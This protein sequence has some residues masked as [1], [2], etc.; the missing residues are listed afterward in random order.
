[1]HRLQVPSIPREESKVSILEHDVVLSGSKGRERCRAMFDSSASYSIIRR[2]LA[3]RLANLE[4]L[5][6]LEE[7]VFETA[8]PG[9][10]IQA[11]HAVLLV[12]HF[13]DSQERFS[14]EFIV[15]DALPEALIVGAHSIQAWHVTLDFKNESV[16]YPKTARRLRV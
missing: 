4:P 3:E 11:R 8:R 9:D 6:D 1:M 15:F 16:T 5:K 13:D 2:D 12:L 7:W 14:D 10:L